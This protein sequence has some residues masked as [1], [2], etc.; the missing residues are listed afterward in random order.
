MSA[1]TIADAEKQ[2][3]CQ[4]A[5]CRAHTA[6][7]LMFMARRLM[8]HDLAK[9]ASEVTQSTVRCRLQPRKGPIHVDFATPFNQQRSHT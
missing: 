3:Y 9:L 2:R 5:I 6:E 1:R 4:H 8:R 7:E